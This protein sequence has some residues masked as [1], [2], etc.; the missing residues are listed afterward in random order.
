MHHLVEVVETN[1]LMVKFHD[2]LELLNELLV[3]GTVCHLAYG[4][5]FLQQFLGVVLNILLWNVAHTILCELHAS[6]LLGSSLHV[7]VVDLYLCCYGELVLCQVPCQHVKATLVVLI[8][9]L[10]LVFLGLEVLLIVGEKNAL[11]HLVRILELANLL[12]NVCTH[13][14]QELEVGVA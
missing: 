4:L 9:E 11:E 10:L 12:E 8:D 7:L 6:H 14:L 5:L 2:V 3:E 1:L 13:I